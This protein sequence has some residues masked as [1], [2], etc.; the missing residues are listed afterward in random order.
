MS[1]IIE[2]PPSNEHRD[3]FISNLKYAVTQLEPEEIVGVIE[4]INFYSLPGYFLNDYKFAIDTIK[5][6]GSNNL[7]LMVDIFHMQMICG[8]ISNNLK[9]FAPYI[10]HV[11]IAQAPNRNEPSTDG[12][13]NYRFI[14]KQLASSGYDDFIGLEYKPL[15]N[16][17]EGLKWIEHFGYALTD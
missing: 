2:N 3:T 5:A 12:E 7:K 16:T 15:N 6:I 14:L 8:N 11:Q 13:L 10:G 9:D 1:G 17:V 4:P